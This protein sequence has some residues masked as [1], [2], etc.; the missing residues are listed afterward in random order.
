MKPDFETAIIGA[1]FGGIIAALRLLESGRKSF[2]IFERASEIGGTWRDNTYPGCACDIPS[3]L[4]SIQSEPNP[5][6]SRRYSPQPEIL[7]YLKNVVLKHQLNPYIRF[8]SDIVKFEYISEYGFWELTDQLGRRTTARLVITALGPFQS[9]KI[10]ELPGLGNFVGSVLHSAR[11]DH[12]VDLKGKRV[13]VV[14]TGASAIQIVPAV[15]PEVAQLTV[16]QRTPAWVSDRF[17]HEI[18][19]LYK[20]AFHRFPILQRVVR[21]SW[22]RFLEFRGGLFFGNKAKYRLFEKLCLK[23]LKREVADPEVRRRLTPDY[24]MGCKRMLVSDDYF[25]AFNRPNV[26]LETQSIAQITPT[27]IATKAGVE[28]AFDVIIFATG[29]EVVDFDRMK[30]FGLNGRELYS[31]WKQTGITA[32]KGTVVSGFP[33]FCTLLG[34]NSGFGH[35]SVLLAMEAQMNYVLQY[36]A[37]L[38][39]QPENTGLDLKAEAQRSYNEAL[40]RKF[41]GTVWASGCKSWYLDEQGNNPVIYPGLMGDF[42]QE[43]KRFNPADFQPVSVFAGIAHF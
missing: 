29:F 12:R 2:I 13:A 37:Y 27:G 30:L 15:A 7:A 31:E 28:R 36:L 33:N 32:Y 21:S 3:N 25:P 6:W 26:L 20:G 35:N 14:G 17:D 40:Q 18:P 23:K 4:Y 8:D 43:T 1:G 9:P 10:P 19:S 11:W 41:K 24:A 5:D 22:Y 39:Q 38:E 16:F 42:Q 34:P